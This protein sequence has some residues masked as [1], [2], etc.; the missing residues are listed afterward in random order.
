MDTP[1]CTQA[2]GSQDQRLRDLLQ[3][4]PV[5]R[6]AAV[7]ADGNPQPVPEDLALGVDQLRIASP[8]L[9]AYL[10]ED[11]PGILRAFDQALSS[12]VGCAVARALN[13]PEVLLEVHLVDMTRTHNVLISI[14]VV[15]GIGA[16]SA[17]L[18]EL[19]V[20]APR[21]ARITKGHTAAILEIDQATTSILGWAAEDM[22]GRRSLE[23]IHP[24]D[25]HLAIENWLRLRTDP[26]APVR[27]RLRHQTADGLWMWFEVS[28]TNQLDSPA[29][30]VIAEMVDISA[31][32]AAQ[33]ALAAR[34]Q[35]L[36]QLTQTLP[37]GVFQIDAFGA[38]VYT[39][40][41][42]F[43]IVGQ[44]DASTVLALFA[45]VAAEQQSQ[46]HDAVN[47]VLQG[48]RE[49]T[50]E[51]QLNSAATRQQQ[52][53]RITL[54][55]LADTDGHIIGAVGCVDDVT[56]SVTMRL[57]LEHRATYDSLTGCL[58]RQAVLTQLERDLAAMT[59]RSCA[60]IA[61]IFVDLDVFKTVNDEFGHDVG[62][63]LLKHTADRL[64]STVNDRA[65]VGRIGGD[66]FLIIGPN[67]NPSAAAL[68]ADDIAAALRTEAAMGDRRIPT[69]ASVGVA[70][71]NDPACPGDQLI[72]EADTAMY[73]SK[74]ARQGRAVVSQHVPRPREKAEMTVAP[75]ALPSHQSWQASTV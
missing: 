73:A 39:N 17:R 23:F 55:P 7:S 38:L 25:Q 70:W 58:N 22:V 13:A 62:N 28:Q 54:R 51:I 41:R 37:L 72:A 44:Q 68:L 29:A 46:L 24:D 11:R 71:T 19:P 3:V 66:E 1:H 32:M 50:S 69:S 6:I 43:D 5:A 59:P 21:V 65:T 26:D 34:E 18:A 35:L 75:G 42:L 64:R 36:H 74:R 14:S 52:T 56:E 10:P 33:Q 16:S 15:Q 30:C 49:H 40:E 45:H 61:A 63:Q 2:A 53:C 67:L 60:G 9:S 48:T 27:A 47:A 8:G 20:V 57:E 4:H 31:E 12:G